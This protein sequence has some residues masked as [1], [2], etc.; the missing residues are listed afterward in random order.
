MLAMMSSDPFIS[1]TTRNAAGLSLRSWTK[2]GYRNRFL[3]ISIQFPIRCRS[4]FWASSLRLKGSS[5]FTASL[6]PNQLQ[7]VRQPEASQEKPFSG[8]QPVACVGRANSST[9]SW[10]VKPRRS[11]SQFCLRASMN[12]GSRFRCTLPIAAWGSSGLR[13]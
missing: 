3:P 6:K 13:L 4:S 8:S 1:L 2:A 5:G 10:A 7:S 12:S 9:S 11:V